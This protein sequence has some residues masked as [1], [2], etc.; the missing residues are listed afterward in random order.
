E[1]VNIVTKSLFKKYRTA[2]D[3]ATVH[4]AELEQDI[5]ST[6]FYRAKTKNIM[7]CCKL[8][9]DRFNGVVP[10]TM[11]ELVQLPGVGRKTANVVL[12]GAY[13]KTEGIVVDTHVG[14]LSQ[15]LG[16]S[17]NEDA[18]KIETDLMEIIPKKDWILIGNLLIRHGR[19]TCQA[20]K[21]KCPA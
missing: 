1:R 6:G 11:E 17:R 18:V 14:R 15:R 19:T 20:R 16:F 5:K 2:K 7:G 3:Y 9:V 21:P 13:G 12:G 4:P 8:L 10:Q